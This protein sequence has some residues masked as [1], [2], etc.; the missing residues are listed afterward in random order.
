ME[1]N[2]ILKSNIAFGKMA[3]GHQAILLNQIW[4]IT[5]PKNFTVPTDSRMIKNM[6]QINKQHFL[7]TDKISWLTLLLM[8]SCLSVVLR[9]RLYSS[10]L[11]NHLSPAS[12]G[13]TELYPVL[14]D[15]GCCCGPLWLFSHGIPTHSTHTFYFPHRGPAGSRRLCAFIFV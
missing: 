7:R 6:L 1:Y 10:V 15:P 12:L 11:E 4:I 8:Y 5:Y 13:E 3:N 2:W 14:K 9:I